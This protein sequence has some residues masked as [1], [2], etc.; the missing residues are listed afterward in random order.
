[1]GENVMGQSVSGQ[2]V[3]GSG[4]MGTLA[5]DLLLALAPVE[6][7]Q[8]YTER[9][10]ILYNLGIGLGAA[11]A[12]DAA[13]LRYVV[14]P[15]LVS[16]PTMACVLGTAWS[17]LHDPRLGIDFSK[18]VHGEEEIEMLGPLAAS[19]R[20]RGIS[21][22][23]GL[24]DRGADKGAV[25]RTSKTLVNA[26]G[27]P[28]AVC[29]STQ[30]LRGNGGFGG[31][32]QGMPKAE[33]L[34]ECDPDGALDVT[35]RPEQALIYRLSGDANPLHAV[36]AVARDVGF[37]RPILHGLCSFGLAAR[38][39]VSVLADGDASRLRRLR[40]RFA[41]PVYPGET[42]RVE[43]WRLGAGEAAF[44]ARVVDRDKVVL[45]GGRAFAAAAGADAAPSVI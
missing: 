8:S 36:P 6:T 18:V 34:P 3:S 25:M 21:R 45:T 20:V 1:M 10:T 28:V 39:L 38:A 16:F 32:T 22:V 41:S 44:R 30:M 43:Y 27:E 17:L 29:R 12:E 4:T 15:N 40:L 24:W 2:S 19:G 33:P 9:D 11:V 7:D 14:E 37:P 35:T 42:L 13:L 26:A 23:E 5:P 31:T